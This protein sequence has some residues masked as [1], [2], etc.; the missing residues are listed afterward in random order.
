[1]TRG[2]KSSEKKACYDAFYFGFVL[3]IWGIWYNVDITGLATLIFAV[4]A[5]LMWYAGNRTAYKFKNGE[6]E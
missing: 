1:M 4:T 3:A 5:P 2:S 6:S